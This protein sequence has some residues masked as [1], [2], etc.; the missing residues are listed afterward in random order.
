MNFLVGKMW[1]KTVF[2]IEL[3][4]FWSGSTHQPL[5]ISALAILTRGN[6][7]FIIRQHRVHCTLV[8]EKYLLQTVMPPAVKITPRGESLEM[9]LL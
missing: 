6:V 9:S 1:P 8:S 2:D 7:G 3:K 4:C 5:F